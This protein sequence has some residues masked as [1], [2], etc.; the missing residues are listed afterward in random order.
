MITVVRHPYTLYDAKRKGKVGFYVGRGKSA[1]AETC[2]LGN[3]FRGPNRE[4]AIH[5]YRY[6]LEHSLQMDEKVQRVFEQIL[7]TARTHDVVLICHCAPLACHADVIKEMI[8]EQ[9]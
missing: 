1:A 5:Y 4:R 3:P 8:E 2:T 6:W 9:L 7:N